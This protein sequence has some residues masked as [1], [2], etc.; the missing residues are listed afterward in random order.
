MNRYD[1]IVSSPMEDVMPKLIIRAY[2]DKDKAAKEV[3]KYHKVIYYNDNGYIVSRPESVL[4]QMGDEYFEIHGI[5]G[6]MSLPPERKK[7]RVAK[8]RGSINHIEIS[9]V[10]NSSYYPVGFEGDV[11]YRCSQKVSNLFKGD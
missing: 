8:M 4:K 11:S 9:L 2:K 3:F 7:S 1:E 6:N 10:D 5:Y